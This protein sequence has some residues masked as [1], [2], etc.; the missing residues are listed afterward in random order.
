MT[1]CITL[2]C[3]LTLSS[4]WCLRPSTS[5]PSSDA[6]STHWTRWAPSMVS[7][8]ATCRPTDRRCKSSSKNRVCCSD[9]MLVFF[10][11]RALC[12]M[13]RIVRVGKTG[14]YPQLFKSGELVGVGED[15]MVCASLCCLNVRKWI[16]L[17]LLYRRLMHLVSLDAD[18]A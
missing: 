16:V 14:V 5:N 9:M 11:S 17:S 3:R 8:S 1:P 6:S 15:I 13:S 10:M 2:S 18:H 12:V 7:F 4:W